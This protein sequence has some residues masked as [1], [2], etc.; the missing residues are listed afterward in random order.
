MSLLRLIRFPN[1][2]IIALVQS[3][4]YFYLLLPSFHRYNI[5]PRLTIVQFVYLVA[6]TLSITIGGYIVNDLYD[7]EADLLNRKDKVIIDVKIPAQVCMWLYAVV[8]FIGLMLSIYVAFRIEQIHMAYLYVFSAALLVVYTRKLKKLPLVGNLLV[9]FFCA[10]VAALIW[11]AEIPGWWELQAKAPSSAQTLQTIFI[12][13]F[14]FAFFS[15]FFREIVKDLE[16]KIGDAIAGC[17]TYPIVA[18]DNAAKALASVLAILLI[19]LLLTLFV[20]KSPGFGTWFYLCAALG[21]VFPLVYALY[22]LRQAQVAADYHRIS[23]IAKM[24]MLA[25]ILLLFFVKIT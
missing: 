4:L 2:L 1:L 13:Y 7:Y 22:L 14:S 21:V 11:L 23:F 3:I 5:N 19:L 24:V 20:L 16:D 17:R 6:A 10:G 15:T 25:G 9:S 12:W 18:G 8:G